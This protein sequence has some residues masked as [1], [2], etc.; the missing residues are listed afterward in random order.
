[1]PERRPDLSVVIPSVNGWDDLRDALAAL[2]GQ[3]GD[4]AL[5]VIVVDRVGDSV[6]G[7]LRSDYP[8]VTLI[9]VAAAV[10]I[11]LMRA[12]GFAACR[13]G[14][15][16]VI[17]D[18]VIVPPDWAQR[19]L[20]AHE[21]GAVVVGGAVVNAACDRLVDWAAFLCEYSHCLEPPAGV[22]E[23]LTG[24]NVT[25]RRELL[26]RFRATIEEGRWEDHLHGALRAS[27]VPLLSRPDIVVGHKKHYS[28]RQ[29]LQQRYLYARAFAGMRLE[30]AGRLRRMGYGGAAL[31]L[32]GLLFYRIVSR[33]LAAQRHGRELIRSLPLLALFVSA[34]A[35]GEVVGSWRGPG[36]TLARVC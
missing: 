27:G 11:P 26:E 17:E 4:G 31:L 10:P 36:D 2:A 18:H 28:I 1:M 5:E 23:W 7:P 22:A 35:A 14:I 8:E 33:V 29:Y 21:A 34:W 25:Y 9:E 19:M 13:A 6:R 30:A 24:N 16:G 20:A 3:T 12:A 32:P 15:V